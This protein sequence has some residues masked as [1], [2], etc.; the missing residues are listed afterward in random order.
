M[1]MRV[2]PRRQEATPAAAPADNAKT[3]GPARAAAVS[4]PGY[5]AVFVDYYRRDKHDGDH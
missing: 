1:L 2:G 4:L 5:L 3:D